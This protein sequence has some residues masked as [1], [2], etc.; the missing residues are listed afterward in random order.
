M[1]GAALMLLFAYRFRDKPSVGRAVLVG[2]MCGLLTITHSDQALLL[3]FLLAPLV[4]LAREI[5]R[6]TRWL[7]L[8]AATTAAI[9]VAAPWAAYNTGR[10]N[11]P[12]LV[13]TELGSTLATANCTKAYFG[14][15]LGWDGGCVFGAAFAVGR[16]D[17][18]STNDIR[19]RHHAVDYI[20]DHFGRI[21]IVIAAREGRVFGVFRP[22]QQMRFD[23]F[24]GTPK[25]YIR[26]SFFVTWALELA[27]IAGII[28]MRRRRI[29]VYPILAFIASV[30]IGVALT[31]GQTR[32]RAPAEVSIA[33]LVAAAID[34]LLQRLGPRHPAPARESE[35]QLIGS[36]EPLVS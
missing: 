17:D 35:N 8:A 32:F 18:E 30:V 12:V 9:A 25:G 34:S 21:P 11:H 23:T 19:L 5:P 4:L 26:V 3:V 7:W 27:A 6:R 31:Y 29:A 36:P 2:V 14:P 13:S 33:L 1:L 28:V 16:S 20:K 24:R 15:R 10:F 22:G